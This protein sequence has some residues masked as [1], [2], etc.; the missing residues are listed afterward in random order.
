MY[1]CTTNTL[2]GLYLI[3]ALNFRRG[4]KIR[5]LKNEINIRFSKFII[6]RK[7]ERVRSAI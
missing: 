4:L 5:T 1:N 7:G 2:S 6:C 3:R